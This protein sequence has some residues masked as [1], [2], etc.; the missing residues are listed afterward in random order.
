MNVQRYVVSDLVS[1]TKVLRSG[2]RLLL[3]GT[4]YTARDAAHKR[5]V[6]LIKEKKELPFLLKDSCV[7]YCGPSAVKH[8]S[9]VVVC[10]PTTSYRMDVF[11]EMFLEK[12]AKIFI[13][14]GRRSDTVKN[15]I[16]KHEALYLVATGGIAALLSKTVQECELV[17][18]D[19]LGPEAVYKL[20]VKDMPL[21]VAIDAD[22]NDIFCRKN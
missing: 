5:I 3:S 2:E 18:F 19:D 7:Y 13:G 17:G 10:G 22:G 12:G 6:E 15:C 4:V 16:K 9:Y 21:T 8:S 1:N 14:K 20:V 11:A